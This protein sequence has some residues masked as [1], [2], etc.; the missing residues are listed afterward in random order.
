ME[1]IT[2]LLLIKIDHISVHITIIE[3]IR[4]LLTMAAVK[5]IKRNQNQKINEIT[6]FLCLRKTI[7]IID[8]MTV[9]SFKNYYFF[10]HIE[11]REEPIN[12]H[13][14][15]AK[16]RDLKK[17]FNCHKNFFKKVFVSFSNLQIKKNEKDFFFL[18]NNYAYEITRFV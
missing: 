13:Y 10:V 1:V 3:I 7:Q 12:I 11:R 17:A 15:F 4:W 8:L 5:K 18:N 2:H 16:L 9:K 6:L 14:L